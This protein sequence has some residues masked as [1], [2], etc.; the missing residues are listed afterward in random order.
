MN[1]R[2]ILNI[3]QFTVLAIFG[4]AFIFGGVKALSESYFWI[5]YTILCIFTLPSLI[6]KVILQDSLTGVTTVVAFL[7]YPITFLIAFGIG[8]VF[9]IPISIPLTLLYFITLAAWNAL[10]F[11]FVK[12]SDEKYLFWLTDKVFTSFTTSLIIIIPAFLLLRQIDSIVA[13]DYLQHQAV[14]NNMTM[15]RLLCIVPSQCSNLFLQDGYTTIF[16]TIWSALSGNM[17]NSLVKTY[18]VIDIIW[19]V[20]LSSIVYKYAILLF[21][22]DIYAV[23]SI[24]IASLSFANWSYEFNFLIP[25]T[26]TFFLFLNVIT[27]KRLDYRKIVFTCI[28]LLLSHFVLGAFLSV[29]LIIKFVILKR[30][31]KAYKKMVRLNFVILLSFL[32]ILLAL[33]LNVAGFSIESV[34]QQ[35]EVSYIG[36]TT[37]MPFPK[38]IQLLTAPLGFSILLLLAGVL[39]YFSNKKKNFEVFFSIV[40]ICINIAVFL[41]APT[42]AGKF[43]I[44]FGIFGSV[45]IVNYLKS[46]EFK[47]NIQLAGVILIIISVATSFVANYSEYL[48]FYKREDGIV[49]ALSTT[50]LGVI[51]YINKNTISCIILSDP[52]T[53]IIVSGLTPYQTA[54][55]QYMS[56]EARE[57]LMVFINEPNLANYAKF[58]DLKDVKN[59]EFCFLYTAR[60]EESMYENS[61]VWTQNIYTLPINNGY[62]VKKNEKLREFFKNN[63]NS[64]LYEDNNYLLFSK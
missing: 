57:S 40:Y 42:Y 55:G 44:G 5:A 11:L 14:V 47:F 3:I 1:I 28:I 63:S 37:N 36:G 15:N 31:K 62:G 51:E 38:N 7:I 27:Q 56:L 17:F 12:E 19:P 39:Y 58:K 52:Y 64:L 59:K 53:Q 16:H 9:N 61:I 18:F 30:I 32:A 34:L 10:F 54:A 41:L 29:I 48:K 22:K 43:L 2:K 26:F 50:D 46:I 49:S 8:S 4:L 20:I 25:Q 24:G 45:L 60:L 13:T 35:N 6:S 23:L 33:L 21:K